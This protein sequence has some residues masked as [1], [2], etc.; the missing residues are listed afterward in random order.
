MQEFS[1]KT[2]TVTCN[3]WLLVWCHDFKQQF[4]K[5]NQYGDSKLEVNVYIQFN[6]AWI[7]M[8]LKLCA[9]CKFFYVEITL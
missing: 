7:F 2:R 6:I 1:N 3:S 8:C 4:V 5:V 9:T